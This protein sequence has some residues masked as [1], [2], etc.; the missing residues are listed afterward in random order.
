MLLSNL[1]TTD[2]FAEPVLELRNCISRAR[3]EHFKLVWLAEG[4]SARRTRVL[5]ALAESEGGAY[6]DLGKTLS[7]ALLDVPLHLRA[8][9]VHECFAACLGS[10]PCAVTCLDHLDILFEP[11][12]KINGAE[13]VKNASRHVVLVAAW[14]GV[15]E[16]GSLVFGPSDHPSHK[17][18]AERDIEA[19][20]YFL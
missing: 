4:T 19:A 18:I 12:L 3:D 1:P 9:S 5:Q 16:G 8:A 11:S 7:S 13:L 6:L 17:E 10:E 2:D 20:L 14:P 15:F